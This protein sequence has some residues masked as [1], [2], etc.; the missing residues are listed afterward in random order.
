MSNLR[1]T[2]STTNDDSIRFLKSRIRS[3]PSE[4]LHSRAYLNDLLRYLCQSFH[5]VGD[6]TA[7]RQTIVPKRPFVY[8]YTIASGIRRLPNVFDT[9]EAFVGSL[10]TASALGSEHE[11]VILTGYPSPQWL[12]ALAARHHIGHDFFYRHMDFVP[13]AQ[14]DWH[15]TPSLPSRSGSYLRL[16]IPSIVFL[17]PEGRSITLD[18]LR[19]ARAAS[20]QQI[21]HKFRNFLAGRSPLTGQ[22]I[23]RGVNIHT[24]DAIILEQAISMT[25]VKTEKG[26]K[27]N[28]SFDFCPTDQLTALTYA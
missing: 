26:S 24:G 17:G 13:S 2:T 11:L 22:S 15:T 3:F 7:D 10:D 25:M 14:R 12:N 6:T 8:S 21:R 1:A 18:E 16:L 23:V 27:G 28:L 9:V 4:P 19:R 5:R 20:R